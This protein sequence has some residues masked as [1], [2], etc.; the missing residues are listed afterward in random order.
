MKLTF[1]LVNQVKQIA[2]PNVSGSHPVSWRPEENKK[3]DAPLN[4]REFFLFIDFELGHQ[5]FASWLQTLLTSVPRSTESLAFPGSQICQPFDRNYIN[6]LPTSQAFRL[7]LELN[8]WLSWIC[9]LPVHPVNLGTHPSLELHVPVFFIM[10]L[11][12]AFSQKKKSSS[13]IYLKKLIAS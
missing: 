6:C 11:S 3:A 10:N 1:R 2:F 5:F 13:I 7:R 8:H 12:L 9:S 4:K